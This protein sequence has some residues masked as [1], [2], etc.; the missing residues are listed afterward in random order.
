VRDKLAHKKILARMP[1]NQTKGNGV[2]DWS[3]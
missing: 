3:R 1:E 2:N